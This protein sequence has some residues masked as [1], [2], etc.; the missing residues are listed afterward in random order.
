M[1]VNPAIER[2][3]FSGED[4]VAIL[5]VDDVGMCGSSLEA[6]ADLWERQSVTCGSVMVP[7]PWF[8]ATAAWA[9][10]TPGVDL[11]VHATLTCEWDGYRW[12]PIST[13]KYDQRI[14]G[15]RAR[16]SQDVG[17]GRKIR[18]A[19]CRQARDANANC[20]GA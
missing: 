6:F 16:F 18:G 11:G 17:S 9:R 14:D 12:G 13:A 4:K 1:N 2:L 15:C 8:R 19:F 3:G 20:V 5:H 10:E 7:C